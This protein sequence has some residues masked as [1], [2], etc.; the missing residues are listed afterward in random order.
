[1]AMK[2]FGRLAL[3][4]AGLCF[5]VFF[6]NVSMGAAGMGVILGDVPEMLLLILSSILFVAGVLALEIAEG[7][8]NPTS[9][10]H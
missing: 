9:V 3:V 10:P 5:F 7:K 6:G 1:M 4:A 8:R 2:E